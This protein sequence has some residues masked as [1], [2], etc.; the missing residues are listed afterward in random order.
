MSPHSSRPRARRVGAHPAVLE[1]ISADFG[2]AVES[3]ANQ[4]QSGFRSAAELIPMI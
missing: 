2:A 3:D 1:S 4:N